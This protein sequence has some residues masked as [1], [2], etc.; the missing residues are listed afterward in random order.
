MGTMIQ[1]LR[2]GWRQLAKYPGFT[3]V[4]LVT[5]A[6]GI[7]ANA[8]IFSVVNAVL[9]RP[10]PFPQPD[11][12]FHLW[13]A[14]PSKG[15]TRNTV[16]PFNFLD[17]R[18]RTHSFEGMAAIS[19]ETMNLSVNGQPVGAAGM[20]VSPEFFSILGVRPLLGRVF[21]PEEGKPGRDSVVVLGYALW[22]SRF[23]GDRGIIGRQIRLDGAPATVIGVMPRGFA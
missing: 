22:Q 4:A 9:L 12:L 19:T 15:Y 10:L 6:L 7:G 3:A 20:D 14:K 13:E 18:D 17:W 1:D 11:R 5:L 2:F 16:N 23:G 21:L 8:A